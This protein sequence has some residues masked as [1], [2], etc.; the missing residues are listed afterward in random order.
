MHTQAVML[1]KIRNPR[2]DA[3]GKAV[4]FKKASALHAP[5]AL[6]VVVVQT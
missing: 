3:L 4:I 1:R 6:A 2:L 5:V